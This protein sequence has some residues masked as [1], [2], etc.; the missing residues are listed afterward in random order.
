M[1]V[2]DIHTHIFP[3]GLA[4]TAIS[5]VE[6][7]ANTTAFL[8]GTAADLRGSMKEAGI[9]RSVQQPVA[10][11]PSQVPGIN[12]WAADLLD[13]DIMSFGGMHP[14]YGDWEDELRRMK[15]AG[16]RGYKLHPEYQK[17]YPD[18]PALFPLYDLTQELGLIILFHT[19]E[20]F[21]IKPPCYSTPYRMRNVLKTFP[22]LRMIYAHMGGWRLWD[23]VERL[24]IGE[25]VYL[26]TSFTMGYISDDRFVNMVRD[27]DPQRVL[28][29]T[30]SPWKSQKDELD[31]LLTLP[32]TDA[33]KELILST[34]AKRLLELP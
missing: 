23:D 34:N 18:D 20:D 2:I 15:A 8:D 14:A 32:F 26:E 28:F 12:R 11:K 27:H 29:G 4:E 5:H 24:I 6:A 21:A 30:D 19:G 13:G 7:E 16:L 31:R 3:D 9:A 25:E 17:F 10:T 33:E 22:F 1:E